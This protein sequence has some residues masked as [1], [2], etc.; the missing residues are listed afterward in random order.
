MDKREQVASDATCLR[1]HD[2]LG[3]D[4]GYRSVNS[5]APFVEDPLGRQGTQRVRC[6]NRVQG[7]GIFRSG[8]TLLRAS[9]T[10]L[11]IALVSSSST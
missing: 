1:R 4:R 9:R 8:S 2:S 5:I 3:S 6:R 7:Q 10:A 11:T